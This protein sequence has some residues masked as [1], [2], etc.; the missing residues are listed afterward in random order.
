M[1]FWF[2]PRSYL[3]LEK[4][5]LAPNNWAWCDGVL[6]VGC[7]VDEIFVIPILCR[8]NTLF[9]CCWF[10]CRC[11]SVNS[12]WLLQALSFVSVYAQPLVTC[13]PWIFQV[14]WIGCWRHILPCLLVLP[15]FLRSF[16]RAT[17]ISAGFSPWVGTT[18]SSAS[19]ASSTHK[20]PN[21]VMVMAKMEAL[22]AC[23]C[24]CY[25]TCWWLHHNSL[26]CRVPRSIPW[27]FPYYFC[28]AS[29]IQ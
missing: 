3:Y 14:L 6:H 23:W 8:W 19:T 1:C 20:L 21:L 16:I 13:Y 9:S 24:A 17:S 7:D 29:I 27:C 2:R 28:N 5:V 12:V 22:V 25:A 26:M 11:S 4:R 15:L 10:C 18:R